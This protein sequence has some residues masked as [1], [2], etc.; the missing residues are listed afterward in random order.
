MMQKK[1][2]YICTYCDKV[3]WKPEEA[4][5]CERTHAN[6]EILKITDVCEYDRV[7]RFPNKILV[8]DTEQKSQFAEYKLTRTLN[9]DDAFQNNITQT[10][11]VSVKTNA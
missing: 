8:K 10:G 2:C 3:Y 6:K 4:L 1:E 7:C 5:E 11:E 9:R